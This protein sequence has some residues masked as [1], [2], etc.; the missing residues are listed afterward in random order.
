M[1]I[2]PFADAALAADTR[3]RIDDHPPEVGRVHVV[4]DQ[5]HAVVDRAQLDAHRRPRASGTRVIDD[6]DVLGFLLARLGLLGRFLRI[7]NGHRQSTSR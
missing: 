1:S 2:G 5:D 4:F 3:Q 7:E 6:R